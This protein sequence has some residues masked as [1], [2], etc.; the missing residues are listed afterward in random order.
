VIVASSSGSIH[1]QWMATNGS[2]L[3]AAPVDVVDNVGT[4]AFAVAATGGTDYLAYWTA[5]TT[6]G[7]LFSDDVQ[8]PSD[9]GLGGG[10]DAGPSGP[11]GGA[12]AGADAGI[13]GGTA[14]ASDDVERFD[15]D[16]GAPSLDGEAS[17]ASA[18][19][20][21]VP[22][23]SGREDATAPLDAMAA[24]DATSSAD[25]SSPAEEAGDAA[26]DAAQATAGSNGSS[27]CGCTTTGSARSDWSALLLIGAA[28]QV[29][30]RRR[31]VASLVTHG[32]LEGRRR[33]VRRTHT[34]SP[35]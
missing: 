18:E 19:D 6:M 21:G 23:D 14:D 12:D 11:E 31:A 5:T 16:A 29:F 22:H 9:A 34:R 27:G 2:F 25:A 26:S 10:Q 20:A 13:D 17:D 3:H 33:E 24:L 35:P 32:G 7:V 1:A 30:L 8:E 28:A 15:A 4:A